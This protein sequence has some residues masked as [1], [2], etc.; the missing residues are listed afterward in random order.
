MSVNLVVRAAAIDPAAQLVEVVER[1]G[2]G[3]PDTICDAVSEAVSCALCRYYIAH[4][5]AV[6]HHNVDKVLLVGGTSM[7]AFGGGTMTAAPQLFIAGRATAAWNGT[8]IPID[9]IARTAAREWFDANLRPEFNEHVAVH[10]LMRPVSGDLQAL[11]TRGL[12]RPL[13]NDTS[14][15]AGF[16]PLTPLEQ[17]VL[18]VERALSDP[19]WKRTHPAVG[20]DIKVMGVRRASLVTLTVGRAIVGRYLDG[21]AAYDAQKSVVARMATELAHTVAPHLETTVAVNVAD[22]A[23]SGSRYLTVSGTSAEAGDDGET[24]RGNRANGLITPYRPMTMEAAAGK[25]PMTH[26]GKLYQLLATDIAERIVTDV[27]SVQMAQCVL[28]SQ[29]GRPVSEP[30]VVD[31]A[32]AG[33][34]PQEHDR[35]QSIADAVLAHVDAV[36]GTLIRGERS[37]F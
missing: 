4:C 14:C 1:K 29:I 7:P 19:S 8:T 10:P 25:N 26:V 20:E 33:R 35:I 22:D 3:H 15:G 24:G 36:A 28:V 2:R 23:A 12:D 11:F 30:L 17:V 13:A 37:V 18:R 5:G 6:L 21:P 31:V 34:Q 16:A 9:E 27:D 32:L